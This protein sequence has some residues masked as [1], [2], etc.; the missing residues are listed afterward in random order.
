MIAEI[1][2]RFNPR[3]IILSTPVP[4]LSL[5]SHKSSPQ[6]KKELAVYTEAIIN[7][8]KES[9]ADVLDFSGLVQKLSKPDLAGKNSISDNGINFSNLGYWQLV[10]QAD[11]QTGAASAAKH[12][13][14]RGGG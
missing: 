14:G 6:R 12:A 1:R 9:Q 10:N 7:L 3:R 13:A 8:A 4:P 2:K 11:K 5:N